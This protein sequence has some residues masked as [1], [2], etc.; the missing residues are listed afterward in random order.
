MET[1]ESNLTKTTTRTLTLNQARENTSKWKEIAEKPSIAINVM[2]LGFCFEITREQYNTYLKDN[3]E[4]YVHIYFV[5]N[6]EHNQFY[7]YM[8][9]DKADKNLKGA[10]P[11]AEISN[12]V[13]KANFTREIENSEKLSIFNPFAEFDNGTEVSREEA[14]NRNFLWN[15]YGYQWMT[16]TQYKPQVICMPR[17]NFEK[18]FQLG[19]GINKAIAFY[20]LKKKEVENPLPIGEQTPLANKYEVEFIISNY[21]NTT[22]E[23]PQSFLMYNTSRPVPPFSGDIGKD[24]FNLI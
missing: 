20:G 6:E 22:E 21:I 17:E 19:S 1:F 15:V 5:T 10:D 23:K 7:V 2:N 3:S 18:L 9:G 11:E 14:L 16:N 13:L 24:D 4:N 12:L 8:I